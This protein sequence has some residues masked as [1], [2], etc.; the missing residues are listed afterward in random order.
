MIGPGLL[1]IL[2]LE[3]NND[4]LKHYSHLSGSSEVENLDDLS[5]SAF[6]PLHSQTIDFWASSCIW[7]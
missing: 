4:D 2:F 5:G 1:P 7:S 3:T 6:K